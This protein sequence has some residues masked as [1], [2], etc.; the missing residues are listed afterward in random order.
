MP[1]QLSFPF[2]DQWGQRVIAN[3]LTFTGQ[4]THPEVQPTRV[5]GRLRERVVLVVVASVVETTTAPAE[6]E[7]TL[8]W[9][10]TLKPYEAY[11]LHDAEQVLDGLRERTLAELTTGA[12]GR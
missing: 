10:T 11:E 3:R 5:M 7:G 6:A 4:I 2:E 1:D 9:L 8:R 12:E